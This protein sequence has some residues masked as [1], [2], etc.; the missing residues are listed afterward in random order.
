MQPY[1]LERFR[2]RGRC[3]SWCLLYVW[4]FTPDHRVN[5]GVDYWKHVPICCVWVLWLAFILI[6][7]ST[8]LCIIIL[9]G[10]WYSLFRRLL[11]YAGHNAHSTIQRS[12]CIYNLEWQR[13]TARSCPPS[14][15]GRSRRSRMFVLYLSFPSNIHFFMPC[16]SSFTKPTLLSLNS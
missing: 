15:P 13:S 4:W 14:R 11:V 7:Q 16:Y 12:S 2:R 1:G 9:T 10:Y 6:C 8:N 5:Y 3:H